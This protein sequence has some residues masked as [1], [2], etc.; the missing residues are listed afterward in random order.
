[1]G[2]YSKL[3]FLLIIAKTLMAID[4]FYLKQSY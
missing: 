3:F 2:R 4:Y 1:M